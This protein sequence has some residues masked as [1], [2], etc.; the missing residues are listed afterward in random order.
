MKA[1]DIRTALAHIGGQRGGSEGGNTT[2]TGA[3]LGGIGLGEHVTST[4]TQFAGPPIGITWVYG[5]EPRHT[6][7]PH[8]A[9]DDHR[10]D[11]LKDERL[12]PPA[13]YDWLGARMHPGDHD[14][15]RCH[16]PPAWIL[17]ENAGPMEPEL[18]QEITAAL[19]DESPAMRNIRMLA[20]T[21]D[22]AGRS[23]TVAQA[24]RDERDRILRIRDEWL[25]HVRK[26]S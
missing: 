18:R 3:P 11:S 6:F 9:L 13:G 5:V 4:I 26:A 19:A 7:H 22:A 25:Y 21:D 10:F 15:C 2:H 12:M 23:G 17:P 20:E 14:G 24:Q 16:T 1:G 8:L